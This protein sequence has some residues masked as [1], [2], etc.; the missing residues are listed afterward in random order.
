[1]ELPLNWERHERRVEERCGR[2]DES[3]FDWKVQ[4]LDYTVYEKAQVGVVQTVGSWE[5][6]RNY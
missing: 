2:E 3:C 5:R 6:G 1:M 4:Q